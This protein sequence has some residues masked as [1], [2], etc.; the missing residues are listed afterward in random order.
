MSS[1]LRKPFRYTYKNACRII[2]AINVAVFVLLELFAVFGFP[3]LQGLFAL[4]PHFVINKKM[5]WQVFTYQFLHGGIWHLFFNMLALLFFGIPLEQK[6]GTKEFVLFYLLCGTLCG[7]V[8]LGIYYFIW[9]KYGI[10]IIVIGSSGA[11]F[12]IMLAFA[13]LY[14]TS[15]IFIWGIFPVPA[16]ILILIYIAFE[17]YGMFF[18][19]GGVAHSIHLS[20]LAWAFLYI[21]IRFGINPIRVWRNTFK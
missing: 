2:I 18:S 16:P 21:V 5:F 6:M 11:V 19:S 9:I 3:Q 8:G 1:F 7:I 17:L 20:G 13:V 15:T 4:V 10:P 12:S 14:P